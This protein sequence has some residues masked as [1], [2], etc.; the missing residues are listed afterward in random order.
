MEIDLST[1]LKAKDRVVELPNPIIGASGS[2]GFGPELSDVVDY[3]KIGAI[4]LKSLAPFV[5]P[6]NPAPRVAATKGG[7]MN[8]VGQPG[9]DIRE[10][11]KEGFKDLE[12]LKGRFIMSFWGKTVEDYKIAAGALAPIK[13]H[14]LGI[15]INLSCP[16]VHGDGLFFAQVPEQTS[17]IIQVA[18]QELGDD[19]FISAKLTAAVRSV[20]EVG[21]AAVE[22]GTDAFTLFNT[23]L[24]LQIDPYTRR[25]ILGQGGG[26]YSGSAILPIV[27]RGVY[28]MHKKF[29]EVPII[30]TGGVTSGK[31]AA[32][33]LMC[34][35]S[36][37]GVAA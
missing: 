7:M 1:E 9:P 11:I 33:M 23:L 2:F 15:E 3:E 29:P 34:G 16:N 5:S 28:E 12:N 20:T 24:G 14:F 36:A 35:A 26:G 25:P 31:D 21:Q 13:E 22:A 19:C 37:V 27:L 8:S 10:W 30:G 17:E 18:R 4:T 6:G 32:S